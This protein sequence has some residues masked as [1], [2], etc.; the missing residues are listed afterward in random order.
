MLAPTGC[1]TGDTLVTTDRGLT[2][3]A[4]LGDVW[5]EKWQDL[6]LRVSTDDGE[7]VATKF[8]V[9]G[10]EPTRRVVTEGGYRIQGTLAHR[11]KV[12]DS[13]TGEWVWR[14]MA[15]VAPGDVVPVQLG[16]L[17]GE[18]RRVPLPVLDQAYYAGDR[19]V[20]V[21]EQV[22]AEL[23]ELVGYFM[24]DGS[25]HAKGIR[26][27]VADTDTDVVDRLTV[28]GKGLFNLAPVVSAQQGYQEV[29]LQSVRLARWWQAAGFAKNLPGVD[30][31][32]KGWTPRVP[33]AVLETNDASVYAAFLRGLFE[34]DGTVLQGVPNVATAS[35]SFA[36]EVRTLMLTLGFPTTTRQSQSGWGGT[37]HQV[38][39]RNIRHA[40]AFGTRV[41][42]M[43]GRK[44]AL[45]ATTASAQAGNRDRIH[46]PREVWQEIVPIGHELRQLVQQGVARGVGLSRDLATR[47]L[48]AT[49][50]A[51]VEHALGY[52]Y[53]AVAANEDGGVQPTYD[54]SVPSNVTYVAG[55]FVSHNTIGFM[56]DCDTTGIEP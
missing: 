32:G 15:E 17:V 18:P 42:F 12:V 22:D 8:F 16:T 55:G 19:E 6:D 41:G 9:N 40:I 23:A 33:S 29:T 31:S 51:R 10:E 3:L 5:G 1:L 34:A 50:D 44:A 14:R 36:A 7:Q 28:L 4:E 24:G 39:V 26:L 30:H 43:G 21:P 35:E 38:R 20:V 49:G 54:L 48:A 2:R 53:E 52:V 46:L 45:L 37:S 27:C 56:M 47:V 11:V 25:L 13:S